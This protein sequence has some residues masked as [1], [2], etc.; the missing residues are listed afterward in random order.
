[1]N[2]KLIAMLDCVE[3]SS[4]SLCFSSR[5]TI[6]LSNHYFDSFFHNNIRVLYILLCMYAQFKFRRRKT[7]YESN[8]LELWFRWFKQNK[9]SSRQTRNTSHIPSSFLWTFSADI[10]SALQYLISVFLFGF[11]HIY[12]SNGFSCFMAKVI[13]LFTKQNI[14]TF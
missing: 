8:L 12:A 1:M 9:K 7:E 14:L 13:E 2:L 4:S 11:D 10:T 6:R 3:M 5:M